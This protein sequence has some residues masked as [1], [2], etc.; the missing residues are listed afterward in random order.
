MATLMMELSSE[1]SSLEAAIGQYAQERTLQ[2]NELICI[3]SRV[4]TAT[5]EELACWTQCVDEDVRGQLQHLLHSAVVLL[6]QDVQPKDIGYRYLQRIVQRRNR[7][8]DFTLDMLEDC[9]PSSH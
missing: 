1:L 3:R 9:L 8:R 6:R 2:A 7:V 4:A 5:F